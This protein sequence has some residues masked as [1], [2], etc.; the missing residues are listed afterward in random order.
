MV[1]SQGLTSMMMSDFVSFAFSAPRFFAAAMTAS[2][3]SFASFSSCSGRVTMQQ[4]VQ[5]KRNPEELQLASSFP[6]RTAGDENVCHLELQPHHHSID[7]G[8]TDLRF[9]RE[10]DCPEGP[11]HAA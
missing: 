10:H 2:F 7:G 1:S 5:S 9:P 4:Q 6:H 3:F 11:K 8:A